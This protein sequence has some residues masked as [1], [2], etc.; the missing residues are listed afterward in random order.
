MN[1]NLIEKGDIVATIKAIYSNKTFVDSIS[2][3]EAPPSHSFGLILDKTNFYAEQGG[4]EADIGSITNHEESSDFSVDD[5]QVYGGYVLHSGFLKY[6]SLKVGD[7]VNCSY[8]E[9]SDIL[10]NFGNVYS[11][12]DGPY[13]TTIPLHIF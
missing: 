2:S 8:D 7:Q 11:L 4:Q 12:V 6:G 1:L 9:V 3:L 10:F 5:V 13:E